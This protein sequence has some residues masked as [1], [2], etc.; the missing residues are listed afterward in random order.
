[1]SILEEVINFIKEFHQGK[2]SGDDR[3]HS[4]IGL[5]SLDTLDLFAF[6]EREYNVRFEDDDMSRMKDITLC[7]LVKEIERRQ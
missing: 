7:D 2:Y 3:I 6:I 4:D 1:M 5:D